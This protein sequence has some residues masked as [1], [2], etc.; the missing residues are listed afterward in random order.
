MSRL[1]AQEDEVRER[2]QQRRQG[3]DHQPAWL[4]TGPN[5]GGAWEIT[6]L[7]GPVT[8]SDDDLEVIRDLYRR[9]VGGWLVAHQERAALAQKLLQ[10]TCSNQ[11][12]RPGP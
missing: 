5:Q 12:I 2:R 11:G 10:P 8:W 7:T 1:V 6:T 3:H 9:E 4:A